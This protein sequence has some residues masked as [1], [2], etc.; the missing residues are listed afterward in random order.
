MKTL[1]YFASG[2]YK[3]DYQQLD[4]DKVFLVDYT[5]RSPYP[6]NRRVRDD[7]LEHPVILEERRGQIQEINRRRRYSGINEFPKEGDYDMS[8]LLNCR[9]ERVS[10]DYSTDLSGWGLINEPSVKEIYKRG[11]VYCLKMDCLEAI[12]YFKNEGIMIDCFVCLNEGLEEGGGRYPINS[13]AFMTRAASILRNEYIHLMKKNYYG[14]E[15]GCTF[16][17]MNDFVEITSNDMNYINPAFFSD[18]NF[19]ADS[20]VYKRLLTH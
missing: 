5:I 18:Y 14:K 2:A 20:Q 3:P 13:D 12:E 8:V 16:D 6:L 4:F 15:I 17:F 1:V 9:T 7:I 10:R 19:M 11:K